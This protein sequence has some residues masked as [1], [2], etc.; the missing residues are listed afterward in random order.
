VDNQT[1]AAL[2]ATNAAKISRNIDIQ[3]S[4]SD[5]S[6]RL[7]HAGLIP[8][9]AGTL[10]SIQKRTQTV[11]IRDLPERANEQSARAP[12][13]RSLPRSCARCDTGSGVRAAKFAINASRRPTWPVRAGRHRSDLLRAA[14][15]LALEGLVPK[16]RDEAL[17]RHP[18]FEPMVIMDA[19]CSLKDVCERMGVSPAA[20][21]S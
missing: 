9:R 5:L 14:C 3:V 4:P 2:T 18:L 1:T 15:E 7:S 21:A 10:A 16:R 8:R 6:Y 17:R 20:E 13:G 12:F 19:L 11:F